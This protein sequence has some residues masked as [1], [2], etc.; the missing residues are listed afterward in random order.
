MATEPR[1]CR[2]AAACDIFNPAPQDTVCTLAC[3]CGP[4][5]NQ[6]CT[7]LSIWPAADKW[8]RPHDTLQCADGPDVAPCY[9]YRTGQ[10]L[11]GPGTGGCPTGYCVCDGFGA[12]VDVGKRT[13]CGAGDP[14]P[15]PPI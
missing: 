10:C 9:R 7:R 11:M 12:P 14:C 13:T 2:T 8:C 5:L 1:C 6:P 3:A 4:M 15:V